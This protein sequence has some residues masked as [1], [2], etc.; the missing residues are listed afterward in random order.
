MRSGALGK[1]SGNERIIPGRQLTQAEV[2]LRMLGDETE[3]CQ[4]GLREKKR[5]A[6]ALVRRG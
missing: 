4:V 2:N 6:A 1:R 5:A 3:E